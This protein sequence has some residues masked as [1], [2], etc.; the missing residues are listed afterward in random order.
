MASIYLKDV[1]VSAGDPPRDLLSQVSVRFEPGT[2]NL[3][4]GVNGSGKSMLLR[5]ILGLQPH[6]EGSITL[7]GAE[8]RRD[9]CSL[10]EIAGVAFQNPD[11]Q[12]FGE[13]VREDVALAADPAGAPVEDSEVDA[14]LQRFGLEESGS[15]PPW[16]LSGGQKRRLALAGAFAGN[17]SVLALDEPFLE[18]D[19]PSIQVLTALLAERRDAGACVIVTSHETADL[20]NVVDQVVVVAAGRI[21]YA[22]GRDGAIEVIGPAVGLR[23]LGTSVPGTSS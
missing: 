15:A 20:W 3:I 19:Y 9:F 18:L 1:T 6:R 23:P 7:N 5:A 2:I 11:L 14:L 12:I 4:L 21:L 17:P 8:L 22:G 16:E 10:H 13:T